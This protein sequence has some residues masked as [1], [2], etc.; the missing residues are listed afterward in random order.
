MHRSY[1]ISRAPYPGKKV[2]S[3]RGGQAVVGQVPVNRDLQGS[4]PSWLYKGWPHL[5]QPGDLD[6]IVSTLP[7]IFRDD[8]LFPVATISA[9]DLDHNIATVAQFCQDNEISL[10]PH[11]K[12]TMSPE[13]IDRQM[14]AGAWAITAATA[15][16]AQ[17]FRG[18]GV[19]RILIAHE[20][21]DPAAVRWVWGELN[22]DPEVQIICLVDSVAAVEAMEHALAATP[23]G[24]QIGVLV[25][26]GMVGGRTGC[27]TIDQAVAVAHAIVA[28]PRLCLLG[29]E[30]YEGVVHSGGDNYS[31]VDEFLLILGDLAARLDGL[32]LFDDLDEIVITAGGSMFPDRVVALLGVDLALSRPT[33]LVIRPGCY[34]THDSVLYAESAPFGVRPPMD[35]CPPLQAALKVWSYVVSRPEPDLVL[36]GFGRR[37]ASYDVDLPKPLVVRRDGHVRNVDGELEVFDL[38]DQHAYVRIPP[39]FDIAVGDIVGC[40]ISHPCTTFDRWRAIP[41]VDEDFDVV[42]VIRT[43]F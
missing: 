14:A 27:R 5:Q 24:P 16:Q 19:Q 33:R 35:T 30:G 36:L 28:S 31:V 37:D 20:V 42:G 41:L 40:G 43:F 2:H 6:Q 22:D 29:V 26:L 11:A 38:N 8:F 7:N 39:G 34:V 1:N 23:E 3:Q 15:S 25:E 10:A 17:I 32:G 21:I 18:F 13:I 12:T 9:A 4:E